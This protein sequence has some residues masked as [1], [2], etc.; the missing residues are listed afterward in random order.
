MVPATLTALDAL[1]RTSN[2]KLD[3]RA[4]PDPE[5]GPRTGR[6]ARTP[7]EEIMCSLFADVLGLPAVGPTDN[8][9]DLGGHSLLGTRLINRVR[10]TLGT[11][12][13]IRSLFQH[14]TPAGLAAALDTTGPGGRTPLRPVPRT[15]ETPL[16]FAQSRLWFINQMEGPSSTYHIPLGLRITGALDVD[17]LRAALDDVVARHESLRTVFPAPGGRPHQKILDPAPPCHLRQI[18]VDPDRLD[19]A[20]AAAVAE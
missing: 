11:D 4:L 1:P 19:E 12:L 5:T 2:G 15:G 18:P 14:P 10:S 17:A 20:I 3:R 7:Q 16:S 6:A 13:P 8:F 9:F